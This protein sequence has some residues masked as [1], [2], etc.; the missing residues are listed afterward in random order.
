MNLLVLSMD[1][2]HWAFVEPLGNRWIHTPNWNRLAAEGIVFQQCFATSSAIED[3]MRTLWT[4]EHPLAWKLR[5][6]ASSKHTPILLPQA[7]QQQGWDTYLLTD[8]ATV[9]A[10][11]E[12][13]FF[14]HVK[15]VNTEQT[16]MS[17][18]RS[19]TDQGPNDPR[20]HCAKRWEEAKS[21]RLFTEMYEQLTY[22]SENSTP[23]FLFWSHLESLGQIWDAPFEFR[24]QY[25]EYDDPDLQ[26][27]A[28]VPR[29]Q[30]KKN[31]DPDELLGIQQAYAGQMSLLDLCLAPL[32]EWLNE[33]T[34][35]R[36][37]ALL[38]MGTRGFPMG[39]H[40]N[41]GDY[42]NLYAE[43]THFPAILR[44]PEGRICAVR[45]QNLAE[46]SDLSAI[47]SE[48]AGLQKASFRLNANLMDWYLFPPP[49]TKKTERL[50]TNANTHSQS[51]FH[52]MAR[53]R[54]RIVTMSENQEFAIITEYWY[55]RYSVAQPESAELYLRKDD[56]F[57]VNDVANRCCEVT[58]ALILT[59]EKF[60][61]DIGNGKDPYRTPL[62][63]VVNIPPE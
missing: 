25:V 38:L 36:Q 58:T 44:L 40:L 10:M 22:L 9:S 50:E 18:L 39:E 57:Q 32:I 62:P 60:R 7:V 13:S 12:V 2:F 6:A 8:S 49:E 4:G 47:L 53:G 43:L 5:V 54:D 48:L 41:I 33:D 61:T 26:D 56:P 46:P 63:E 20:P 3:Q 52:S 14:G 21:V 27:S 19:R 30:L 24:E 1:H 29:Y 17:D 31:Y 34:I 45:S 59:I 37:T 55:L 11:P 42:P 35:G 23:S 51:S 28:W 15:T 16:S